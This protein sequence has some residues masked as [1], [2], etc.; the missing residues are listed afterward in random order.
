MKPL[1]NNY[2]ALLAFPNYAKLSLK[3]AIETT[4]VTL[5]K[6]GYDTAHIDLYIRKET[7][8]IIYLTQLDLQVADTQT[9]IRNKLK[10][11]KKHVRRA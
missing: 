4:F 8:R 1:Y 2:G 9:K 11:V 7:S 5:K 10:K 6:Q 3:E